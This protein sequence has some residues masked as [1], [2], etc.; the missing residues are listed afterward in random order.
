M[1]WIIFGTGSFYRNRR[2][3]LYGAYADMEL[4]AFLD[5]YAADSRKVDGCPVFY[6][7][8]IKEMEYDCIL[9][10]SVSFQSM[11]N[12]LLALDV[13]AEK[14]WHWEDFVREYLSGSIRFFCGN[15][16]IRQGKRVLVLSTYLDYNGGTM[17]AVY[18][19]KALVQ[20]GYDA[21]LAAHDGNLKYVR[22]IAGGGVN[23]FLVPAIEEFQKE[24]QVW[25]RQ[26]DMVIANVFQMLKLAVEI[27][28]IRPV[29]WWI[30]EPTMWYYEKTLQKYPQYADKKR[31]GKINAKAVSAVSQKQ[32]NELFEGKITDTLAWGLPEYDLPDREKEN[33]KTVFAVIGAVTQIKGQDIFLEAIG[34]LSREEREQADFWMIGAF[35]DSEFAK[36]IKSKAHQM[37]VKM[38]GHMSQQQ[39]RT[40]YSKMDV[41]VCPSRIDTLS[42][43]LAEGMMNRRICIAS[44][45][46]GMAK[47]IEDG[48]NGFVCRKEDAEDLA[49]KMRW[50]LKNRDR[51]ESIRELSRKIYE[52]QFTMELFAGRLD[53]AIRETIKNWS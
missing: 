29:L 20:K 18:A 12:Q 40:L 13:P 16:D 1:K 49:G 2:R 34:Y 48:K 41:V 19:V 51:L 3:Q 31:F 8:K 38:F 14:I 44:D 32:F 52:Q 10:M 7:E 22:E 33:D 45:G 9:L 17:A 25:I 24:E 46:T 50:I 27:S 35:S 23:I 37:N 21:Y 4:V 53:N 11:E 43:V 42:I 26:F 6:P 47:L 28:D 5:N 15:P 30:H 36:D 39:I